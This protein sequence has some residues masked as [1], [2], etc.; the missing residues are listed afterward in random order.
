MGM[1]PRC[2]NQAFACCDHAGVLAAPL[3]RTAFAFGLL[4][5]LLLCNLLV[6][7]LVRSQGATSDERPPAEAMLLPD[8]PLG[9]IRLVAVTVDAELVCDDALCQV[10]VSEA[11]HLSN[12]DR[13]KSAEVS[14]KVE[15]YGGADLEVQVQPGPDAQSLGPEAWTVRLAPSGSTRLALSY[16]APLEGQHLLRWHWQPALRAAWRDPQSARITLSLPAVLPE[17]AFLLREPEGFTYTGQALEWAYEDESPQTTIAVW[18]MSPGTWRR[19]EELTLSAEAADYAA[20]IMDVRA[21]GIRRSAPLPDLFPRALG[22]LH[23]ALEVSPSPALYLALADLYMSAAVERSDDNYHLLAVEALEAALARHGDDLR[24]RQQL[25]RAYGEL[26]QS[27]RAAG[28][29]SGALSYQ[30]QA[31]R[32]TGGAVEAGREELLLA[33]AVQM[34]EQ[35]HTTEALVQAGST[36]SPRVQDALFRY[37]PPLRSAR[38]VVQLTDTARSA[39]YHL[40]LY[41]PVAAR[42]R[43]DLNALARSISAISG[44]S[45]E[46]L[47]AGDPDELVFRVHV[48]YGTPDELQLASAA[49][50]ALAGQEPSFIAALVT[51]PWSAAPTEYSVRRT[52]WFDH[53]LYE[54]PLNLEMPPTVRDQQLQYT[55]WR[56]LEVAGGTPT[57]EL[58]RL[59]KEL[60]GLTL[61]HER[62]VWEDLSAS[63]YWSYDVGFPEPTR[64]SEQSWLVGWGQERVLA[65]SYRDYHWVAIAQSALALGGSLV[66]AVLTGRLLRRRTAPRR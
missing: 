27:A 42:S 10:A 12:T 2:S 13:V 25:A 64:L 35:G 1:A 58:S 17:E 39:S 34:A 40:L 33:W 29:P 14:V 3:A 5:V 15:R 65:F 26:A 55:Q 52:P 49:I 6:P 45:A 9:F 61:R 19:L 50:A 16:T 20:L 46:V 18:M 63:T 23:S 66:I 62:Q 48:D 38:T 53:Y 4:A 43:D 36:L 60:T 28:D 22:A 59:E 7:A 56:L 8:G 21:E 32:Y 41:P 30:Q 44:C 11:Y 47:E 37:A 24:V 57:D 54:E 51:A 31:A